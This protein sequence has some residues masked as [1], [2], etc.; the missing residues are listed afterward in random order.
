LKAVMNAPKGDWL[1]FTLISKD[2]TEAFS[3][4]FAE[5]LANERLA[6]SRGIR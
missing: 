5:Q 1:Y 3:N 2:G 6:V 4:T